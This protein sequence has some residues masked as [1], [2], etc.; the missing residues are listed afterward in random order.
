M[1]LPKAGR[2]RA[3]VIEWRFLSR[4]VLVGARGTREWSRVNKVWLRVYFAVAPALLLGYG[5]GGASPQQVISAA[6]AGLVAIIVLLACVLISKVMAAP[7]VLRRDAMRPSFATFVGTVRNDLLHQRVLGLTERLN[8]YRRH[9]QNRGA[10]QANAHADNA[11]AELVR[12]VEKFGQYADQIGLDQ[13]SR[14]RRRAA[15][16]LY[17]EIRG[18]SHNSDVAA[19][20]ERIRQFMR[21]W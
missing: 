13:A 2:H 3:R 16:S 9:A 18:I 11:L 12:D 15:R 7:E 6:V 17:R 5:L 21:T 19:V 10:G 1:T 4:C 8:R 14:K 20:E